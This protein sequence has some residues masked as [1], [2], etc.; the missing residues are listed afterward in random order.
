M[1]LYDASGAGDAPRVVRDV[2]WAGEQG[3]S[4]VE[5]HAVYAPPYD[6]PA[7]QRAGA[8][9][10]GLTCTPDKVRSDVGAQPTL[11]LS[12]SIAGVD[13]RG[14]ALT[15][16][17]AHLAPNGV[18]GSGFTNTGGNRISQRFQAPTENARF[19]LFGENVNDV[20]ATVSVDYYYGLPPRIT[21]FDAVDFQQGIAGHTPD[22]FLLRW[23]VA[24]ASPAAVVSITTTRPSGFHF[25]PGS[26]PSGEYRYSRQG[27]GGETLT[28]TAVNVFGTVSQD[29]VLRWP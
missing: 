19:V 22:S 7:W 6:A 29:L 14:A 25:H 11:D 4:P 24:D 8:P 27:A 17:P 5:A 18:V 23:T 20:P 12:L 13:A 3:V 26:R 1:P 10:L 21:R 28:L 16:V 2:F 9:V 15:V